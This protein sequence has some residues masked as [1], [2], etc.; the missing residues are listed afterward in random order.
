[1]LPLAR[2]ADPGLYH[3]QEVRSWE[4]AVELCEADVLGYRRFVAGAA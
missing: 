4:L 2:G 1:M 3:P